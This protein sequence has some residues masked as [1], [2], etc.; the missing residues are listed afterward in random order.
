MRS[1]GLGQTHAIFEKDQALSW[2]T[3]DRL[4][5]NIIMYMYMYM[6]RLIGSTC[7]VYIYV[8]IQYSNYYSVVVLTVISVPVNSTPQ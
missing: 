5:P 7:T 2:N 1:K 3:M 6:K 4:Y 8:T